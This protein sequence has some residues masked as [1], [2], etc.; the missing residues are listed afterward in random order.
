MKAKHLAEIPDNDKQF[1]PTPPSVAER[2]LSGIDWRYI[3]T[4]LEPEA[5]KPCGNIP[6]GTW[7]RNL[8]C[9]SLCLPKE[10][11]GVV[12]CCGK[13]SVPF[14]TTSLPSVP[15]SHL[16]GFM[17]QRRENSG[18]LPKAGVRGASQPGKHGRWKNG[19][20]NSMFGSLSL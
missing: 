1:Y 4:V 9:R 2:M 3:Q 16:G 15:F 14:T 11:M 13:E 20:G 7:V 6:T 10:T 17:I 12:S 19:W 5:G 8:I 18:T